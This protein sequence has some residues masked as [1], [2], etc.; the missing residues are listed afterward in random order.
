M[1]KN[2]TTMTTMTN[3]SQPQSVL[4]SDFVPPED[5]PYS[6]NELNYLR[7]NTH[8]KMHLSTDKAVHPDC[9]HFYYVRRNS[10]K[11]RE[12]KESGKPESGS[13]SVCWKLRNTPRS[14][15]G[16]AR[17]LVD[18]YNQH[19]FEEQEKFTSPLTYDNLDIES[20][21]YGWLFLER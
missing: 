13:C 1:Y 9:G 11:Q 12:I 16:I 2:M 10:K 6:Q 15:L 18:L 4:F 3:A 14:A 8:Y 5:R 19:F 7:K 17:N 21:Y 20:S